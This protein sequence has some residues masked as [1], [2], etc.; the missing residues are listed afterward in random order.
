[1]SLS[2]G[3]IELLACPV[4]HK[5][6]E[7]HDQKN[8]LTCPQCHRQYPVIDDIPRLIPANFDTLLLDF[9]SKRAK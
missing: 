8:L 4:D 2:P 6:L 3:L 9:Q 1:M 5:E 7:Y